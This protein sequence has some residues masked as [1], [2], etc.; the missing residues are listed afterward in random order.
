MKLCNK[1]IT[2]LNEAEQQKK[3]NEKKS[4]LEPGKKMT[5]KSPLPLDKPPTGSNFL[6]SLSSTSTAGNRVNAKKP[7]M[8][9]LSGSQIKEDTCKHA[10]THIV[11]KEGSKCFSIKVQNSVEVQKKLVQ[12][13]ISQLD[14]FDQVGVKCCL[15]FQSMIWKT[16]SKPPCGQKVETISSANVLF[17]KNQMVGSFCTVC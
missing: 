5:F 9:G 4:E 15:Q 13:E 8:G 12:I 17:M 10:R 14:C 1:P 2:E 7:K 16:A 11:C 6:S 3:L